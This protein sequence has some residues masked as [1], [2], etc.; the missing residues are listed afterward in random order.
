MID[1][2]NHL[3]HADGVLKPG[4]LKNLEL[5]T[6]FHDRTKYASR[7]HVRTLPRLWRSIT[8]VC[9]HQTACWLGERPARWDTVGAHLGVTRN[10]KLIQM[11]PFTKVVYHGNGWNNGT[12][13]IEVDGLYAGIEGDPRTVWDNPETPEREEG[14]VLTPESV[15]AARA[16][17]RWINYEVVKHGGKL[18][19]I[20]AHRQS[21][22]M[23]P[24]DPGSAIWQQVA[25]PL[26]KELGL[27]EGGYGFTLG[28]GQPIPKDWNSDSPYRY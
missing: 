13:G 9:L 4:L 27:T 20:V 28:E 1:Y 19:V 12:V 17:I 25:M 11:H 22:K 16:A 5:P 18:K 15:I 2:I 21:S 14:M 26:H 23:R 10:G 24:N 6:E 7:T 8:G 3:L